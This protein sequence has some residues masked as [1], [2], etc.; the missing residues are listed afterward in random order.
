MRRMKVVARVG[1]GAVWLLWTSGCE[2][3]VDFDRS[4][5]VSDDGGT[6]P[7]EGSTMDAGRKPDAALRD[8]GEAS[9]AAEDPMD[10]EDA[11][12]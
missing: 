4:K 10:D 8:S 6:S 12:R 9:D 7:D 1:L 11:G 3:I 5:V 2:L